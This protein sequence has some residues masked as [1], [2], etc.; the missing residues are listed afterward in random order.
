MIWKI[1]KEALVT[2][3]LRVKRN[4]TI[5][6]QCMRYNDVVECV[7]HVFLMCPYAKEV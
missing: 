6:D 3:E 5:D 1:A 4:L 2:N 7:K